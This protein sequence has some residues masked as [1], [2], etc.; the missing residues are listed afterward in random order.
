MNIS[1]SI[2]KWRTT[3]NAKVNLHDNS[4]MH[5]IWYTLRVLGVIDLHI[6]GLHLHGK[7][8]TLSN[9]CL[10]YRKKLKSSFTVRSIPHRSLH[11]RLLR[12]RLTTHKI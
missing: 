3:F 12:L 7:G 11:N 2:Y 8:D 5:G 10:K 9:V 1:R 6:V 4:I